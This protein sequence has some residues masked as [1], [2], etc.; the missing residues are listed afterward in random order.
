MA[1][2]VFNSG[3]VKLVS[4]VNLL[5]DD[6]RV[7]ILDSGYTPSQDNDVFLDDI[8]THEVSTS[9]GYVAGGY[10]VANK[11]MTQDNSDNEGVFDGDNLVI[12]NVSITGARY[13][14]FYKNTGI[15][16]T[17]PVL[18]IFDLVTD[19]GSSGSTFTVAWPAEG[20][21]NITD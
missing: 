8:N 11:V 12:S 3:K 2:L 18:W 4:G 10:S 15:P 19:H 6:I 5:T 7:A 9:G 13:L 16:A 1:N 14:A 17:S 20:I 21:L